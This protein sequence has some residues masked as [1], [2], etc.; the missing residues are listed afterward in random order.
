MA[1]ATTDQWQIHEICKTWS[2][3]RKH[4]QDRNKPRSRN[5]LADSFSQTLILPVRVWVLTNN[6]KVSS[7]IEILSIKILDESGWPPYSRSNDLTDSTSGSQHFLCCRSTKR[8]PRYVLGPI[9]RCQLLDQNK[10]TLQIN[11]LKKVGGQDGLISRIWARRQQ[12]PHSNCGQSEH[13]QVRRMVAPCRAFFL[14][15]YFKDV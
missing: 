6:I 7:I 10:I 1:S 13:T 2:V 4:D 12:T 9:H 8:M 3:T 15:W 14:W 5:D 11:K